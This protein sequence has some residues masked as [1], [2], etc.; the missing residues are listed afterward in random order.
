MATYKNTN[1]C[2]LFFT[3][4]AFLNSINTFFHF[5]YVE[6]KDNKWVLEF[7]PFDQIIWERKPISIAITNPIKH[8]IDNDKY[9]L[10]KNEVNAEEDVYILKIYNRLHQI[11]VED[12]PV[13]KVSNF[14]PMY[15]HYP[16]ISHIKIFAPY[17]FDNSKFPAWLKGPGLTTLRISNAVF[18]DNY[19]LLYFAFNNWKY[20]QIQQRQAANK[21]RK[22]EPEETPEPVST[23]QQ[24][25]SLNPV[26]PQEIVVEP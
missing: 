13:G 15:N 11:L 4:E 19:A 9:F 23:E 18:K 26:V 5:R 25:V 22:L 2:L 20:I 12:L 10:E 7:R 16:D 21:K 3:P 14:E 6:S 8:N 1:N 17:H 24:T